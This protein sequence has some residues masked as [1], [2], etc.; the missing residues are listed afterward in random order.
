MSDKIQ[1]HGEYFSTHCHLPAGMIAD[2]FDEIERLQSRIELLEA[3]I[4]WIGANT[5]SPSTA[6]YCHNAL[7]AAEDT[8]PNLRKDKDGARQWSREADQAAICKCG[9]PYH[10]HFDS[11]ENWSPVGCKYCPCR[12]F[13]AAAED[14]SRKARCCGG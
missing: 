4:E 7:A 11:Y 6:L 13:V 9:H 10:R 5:D 12:T 3:A 2:L 8:T 1:E 14:K